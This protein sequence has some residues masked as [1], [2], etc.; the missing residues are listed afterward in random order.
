[1]SIGCTF[2]DT[3]KIFAS[4]KEGFEKS[5]NKESLL[6][7]FL[8]AEDVRIQRELTYYGVGRDL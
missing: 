8:P 3:K 5:I 7:F 6:K 4:I 2:E 1:L